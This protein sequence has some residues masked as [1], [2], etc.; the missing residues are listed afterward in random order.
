MQVYNE[1]DFQTEHTLGLFEPDKYFLS[2]TVKGVFELVKDGVCVALPKDKQPKIGRSENYIDNHGNSLKTDGDAQP[3]KPRA[4]CLFIGSAYA[5]GGK[6]MDGFD[7]VFGVGEM[8]KRLSVHGHRKWVRD[9]EGSV[10]LEGPEPIAELPVRAEY[11]HGGPTSS[12]NRHGIGFGPLD[13]TP[14]ASLPAANL[15]PPGVGIVP[16]DKDE[17]SAGLGALPPDVLPRRSLAGTFDAHWLYRRRP[18][19]P[20]DYDTAFHNA[21]RPDQQIEGYLNGNEEIFLKNLHPDAP[22]FRSALPNVAI[23][24]F[25]HR[26]MDPDHPEEFEFAEVATVLDTCIVDVPAGTVTLLWRGTLEVISPAHERI[27]HMLIAAE[28]VD[29]PMTREYYHEVLHTLLPEPRESRMAVSEAALKKVGELN[30]QG[31]EQMLKTLRDGGAPKDLIAKVEKQETVDDAMKI[32][33]DHVEEVKK[34]LPPGL[35]LPGAPED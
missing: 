23:R 15:L 20:I 22:T 28:D 19:P 33:T 3:F 30:K 16:W 13:E 31:L 7:I 1:T 14:G 2:V 35:K 21:A 29:E 18:L 24:C 8:Q 5:P 34:S 25:T 6:P 9:A 11:A 17:E 26:V 27:K 10:R 32:L 12:Y 4:D